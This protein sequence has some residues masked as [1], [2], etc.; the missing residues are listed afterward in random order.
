MIQIEQS[1]NMLNKRVTEISLIAPTIQLAQKTRNIIE[2]RNEEIDVFVPISK[3]DTLNDALRIARNLV[4]QGAKVIISRKGTASAIIE[5]KLNVSVVAI[6]SILSD[7]IESIEVAKYENGIIA[8]FSYGEMTDDVKSLC[9]M[10]DIKAKYYTFKT[11]KDCERIVR[12]SLTDGAVLGI[13][14]VM[15]QKYSEMYNLKHITIENSEVSITSAIET[16]KQILQVQKEESKKQNELK[17]QLERYKAVLNFTHDAIIAV[18]EKGKVDVINPVAEQIVKTS[19][20]YAVGKNIDEI[21][22]NTSMFD[23]ISNKEKQ[24]NQLMDIN[25]TLVSTNRI[26]I[27]VDDKVKGV[28]ATFQDVKVIQENE[29]KIRRSLHEKGLVARYHFRDIK[30]ESDEIKNAI[31]IAKSYASSDSTIL[32]QGETG[33]GKE[34]FAQSIH[35]SSSRK[36]G[37][38][39]AINCA[40]LSSNLLESELFGYVEGAF[41][42]AI[43]GGKIGLFE[44]AHKGTIFLDEI[45]EIPIEIQAQLLRVLQ[46]K[47]IRKVGS[48]VKTPVDVRVITATNRNLIDEMKTKSFREDLYYRIGVLNLTVPPLRERGGDVMLLGRF[49]FD[50]YLGSD[51]T[52]F[53]SMFEHI[54]KRVN[55]YKWYGNIRELQN[56]V[57]RISVLMKYH[58]NGYD[59]EQL[60]SS[61]ISKDYSISN[62][63][64]SIEEDQVCITTSVKGNDLNKW[65]AEKITSALKNNDLSIQKA[66]DALGISRTTLWRKMKQYNIKL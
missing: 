19:P 65:E 12:Q 53:L 55:S 64:D 13:G 14:G 7:Y 25:G 35:N 45:G 58:G 43:K 33:T 8:F 42:G 9:S 11:D 17:V 2:Q 6:N 22:H 15:T 30:G 57:E 10:L 51:K 23:T 61:F 34:L 32:I 62:N 49:F 24:L 47:E 52:K 37:P 59:F 54:M 44:L 27:V 39:V 63:E 66:A 5:S 16:A 26:P 4:E 20:G 36:S 31:S 40:S 18:D 28:V 21:I 50:K 60:V 29:N 46:E 38:F 56:F 48:V 3:E 41:T 1:I